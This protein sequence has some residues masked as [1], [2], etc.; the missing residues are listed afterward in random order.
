MIPWSGT[1]RNPERFNERYILEKN[2]PEDR[3]GVI[4]LFPSFEEWVADTNGKHTE[5]IQ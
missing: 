4:G 5:P 1:R 3:R 2:L